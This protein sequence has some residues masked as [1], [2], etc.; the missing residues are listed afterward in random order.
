MRIRIKPIYTI[1]LVRVP[2][3]PLGG[4]K[5]KDIGDTTAYGPAFTS[6]AEQR[7]SMYNGQIDRSRSPIN[8]A[9]V[10][11]VASPRVEV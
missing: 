1:Q 11:G 2:R 8:V 3:C 7:D 9:T 6:D 10:C 5:P 4:P